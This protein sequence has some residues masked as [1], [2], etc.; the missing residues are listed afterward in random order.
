MRQLEFSR[1][2]LQS[3]ESIQLRVEDFVNS[4]PKKIKLAILD[5]ISSVPSIVLPIDTLA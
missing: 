1:E 4:Y 2:D 5:H 3:P